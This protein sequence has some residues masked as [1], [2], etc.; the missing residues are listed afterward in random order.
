MPLT[1]R[2]SRFVHEY[3]VDMNATNAAVSAGY[4]RK[5]AKSQAS[6]LLTFVDVK[7]EIQRKQKEDETRLRIDRNK[8]LDHLGEAIAV[9]KA[10]RDPMGMIQAAAEINKMLGYYRVFKKR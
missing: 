7:L 5:T 8:V 6:R 4:S 2:Q 9:A 3:L 10:N 1:P